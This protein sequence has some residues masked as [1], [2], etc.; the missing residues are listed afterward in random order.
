MLTPMQDLLRRLPAIEAIL[1]SSEARALARDHAHDFLADCARAVV[2]R[3]RMAIRAGQLD[4]DGLAERVEAAGRELAEVAAERLRP[5]LVRL[6]NATGVVIHTNLGRAPWPQ[7]AIAAATDVAAGYVNLEYDLERGQRGRR[8]DHLADAAQVFGAEAALVVNNNAA[9]VFLALNTLA[10]GRATVVSRGEMVEI[11][12]SFRIPDILA[13]SGSRLREVGTT[14]RTRLADYEAAIDDDVGLLL[15]VHPSNY[16]VLGFTESVTID[17]LAALGRRRGVA[18]VEDLGS[19]QAVDLTSAG[20]DD[21]PT[22]Q[23]SVH[24]GADL[25]LFSGDKLLGGP[26]AGLILGR[27]EVV[28]RLRR[29]P[30]YRALR[31]DKVTIAA[32]AAV[33][34]LYRSGDPWRDVPVL[35]ALASNLA[36]LELRGK[37]IAERLTA[38]GYATSVVP[39]QST[40]GGGAAPLATQ[41]SVQVAVTHGARSAVA[42]ESALR[43]AA[44]PVIATVSDDTIRIDLRTVA[45]ADEDA[46]IDAFRQARSR[47]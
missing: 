27:A 9:A 4:G 44:T 23:S 19:G 32:V 18:V 6:I 37:R 22:V 41:P 13:R 8:E 15:K 40:V 14:N 47:G 16:R 34:R 28:E 42:L 5:S 21:E 7:A 2:D 30:L 46:L 29:N 33:L 43:R 26:Q 12:G 45:E 1:Q 17:E 35:R 31:P 20:I 36:E 24:S 38:L 11:G 10:D 3:W 39:G 25:V